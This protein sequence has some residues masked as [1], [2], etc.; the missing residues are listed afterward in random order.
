MR[1]L[2]FVSIGF[3]FFAPLLCAHEDVSERIHL[4]N[5]SIAQDPRNSALYLQR[6]ELHREL[7]HFNE[8]LQD[9]S[10]ALKMNAEL[11]EASF[12]LGNVYLVQQKPEKALSEFDRFL[13]VN[14]ENLPARLHKANALEQLHKYK[15]AVDEYSSILQ[16]KPSTEVY[17]MAA[18]CLR[19][20]YPKHKGKALQLIQDGIRKLGP[21]ITLQQLAF[22]LA[23]ELQQYDIALAT[24]DSVLKV[25]PN[26]YAWMMKRADTF[27]MA[28]RTREACET[29]EQTSKQI[30]FAR[31][32]S[33][34]AA[35]KNE[36]ATK[37]KL[38][39][40]RIKG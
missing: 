28:G 10:D 19:T 7:G 38:C 11:I 23:V 20:A 29:L 30:E 15:E 6:G 3:L 27:R 25:N 17:L 12:C 36:L 4:L 2:F 32:N 9:C 31:A 35:I 22:D 14:P 13:A 5:E 40:S 16:K 24:V 39:S 18:A 1:I 37:L 26:H 34:I 33:S 21:I 8:A